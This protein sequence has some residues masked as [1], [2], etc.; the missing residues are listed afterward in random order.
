MDDGRSVR[1]ANRAY[2]QLRQPFQKDGMRS[3]KSTDWECSV[4]LYKLPIQPD[5][6]NYLHSQGKQV[7]S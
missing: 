5:H 2:Y 6:G 7:E 1:R 3:S 4:A